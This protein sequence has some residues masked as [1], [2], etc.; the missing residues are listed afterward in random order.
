[1]ICYG[2]G[3]TRPTIT[4]ANLAL[5]RLNPKGLL[6][7]ESPVPLEAIRARIAERVGAPLRLDADQA[8]AAILR[9]ANDRMAGAI[10]MVSLAK[11]H[12]PRDFAL[13]AFGGA[14]P[15][16]AVAL[17]RELA[18]PTVLVPAR[19]GLTNA[20]GCLVADVR[21][22]YVNTVNKPLG[23]VEDAD[24][25]RR[26]EAQIAEGRATIAREGVAVDEIK[27]IHAVEMQFL[28]QTHLLKVPVPG[29]DVGREAL[30]ALFEKAY[31]QRFAVELPEI[32]AVLVNLHTA[33]IGRRKPVAIE[34]LDRRDQRKATLAEAVVERRQVWFAQGGWQE[35]PIYR[36]DLLPAQAEFAGP[37]IVEQL[38]TTL[39]VEPGTTARLDAVGNII[40]AVPIAKESGP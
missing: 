18:I 7:V 36:R 6:K 32:R 39:V 11:G 10:R 24:V 9:I 33:V 14:G 15:L 1:P 12:D 31:F 21:H 26:F 22:D 5:G 37:G 19:P 27:L 3:G 4:D 13:F 35:T 16:H 38:D 34:L 23:E 28:G 30:R 40:V 8:A 2:R 17:A 25:R 20:L 29:I